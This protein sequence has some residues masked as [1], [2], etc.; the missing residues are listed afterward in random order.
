MKMED[1][2]E[3]LWKHFNL[4]SNNPAQGGGILYCMRYSRERLEGHQEQV[5]EGLKRLNGRVEKKERN[6][7]AYANQVPEES[8]D[9]F[10]KLIEELSVVNEALEL[11]SAGFGNY[12]SIADLKEGL[13][14]TYLAAL[15]KD[16]VSAYDLVDAIIPQIVRDLKISAKQGKN[17]K[18][19]ERVDIRELEE[20]ARRHVEI[21]NDPRGFVVLSV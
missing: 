4:T 3:S 17:F 18:A 5:I 6:L 7:V 11:N 16:L 13:I 8:Y 2:Q 19:H 20:F 1:T 21:L 15:E 14:G 9:S 12:K 10:R